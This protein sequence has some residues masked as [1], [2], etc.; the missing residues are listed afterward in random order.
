VRKDNTIAY[1]GN[2]YCLPKG[3]YLGPS[4]RVILKIIDDKLILS[5]SK[6][7]EIARHTIAS[8]KG[9]I[10][11]NNNYN[12]DYSLKIDLL[13]DHI[14]ADYNDPEIVREYLN[15]IRKNNPRYIRDQLA[16]IKKQGQRYGMKVMQQS[17][18][19]CIQNKIFKATDMESVAKK[20]HADTNNPTPE[21]SESIRVK[22]ISKST[23]KI[24]P[25]KSSI[26][27]YK[28]LMN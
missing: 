4:T 28:N 27:D 10:I 24:T 13:I 20:I 7:N 26:S 25:E 12:R 1:K 15:Q 17:L 23:F 19:F 6:Q 11:G 16:L 9:K 2:F 18:S 3:T 14:A 21:P 5:D 8:G 22:S